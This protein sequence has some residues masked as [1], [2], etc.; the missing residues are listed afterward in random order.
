[1]TIRGLPLL[2]FGFDT[3]S[4]TPLDSGIS[5]SGSPSYDDETTVK[6]WYHYIPVCVV[7]LLILAPHPSLLFMLVDFHL[8][9][10]DQYLVFGIHLFVTYALTF[11]AFS[12]LIVC[13]ARDPGPIVIPQPV[14]S[15]DADDSLN[16]TEALMTSSEDY[17]QH[18]GWC[19]KCW[20]PRPER[21]HHCQMCGRCV[22]KMD[23]HCPWLANKCI[24]HRTYPA[25]IHFLTCI[26]LLAL[27]I[28][29]VSIFALKYAFTNPLGVNEVTPMHELGLA[30]AGIVI[31]LVI[32]PFLLY[33]FYLIST[34]QTTLEN[35][36][37]F[38][39]LRD[40]PPLPHGNHF[41][42][43]PPLEAEL[44]SAQRRLVKDAHG[45]IRLYD[46]GWRKNWFQNFGWVHKKTL[47]FR[48]F[49]G[50]SS[51]GD[52]KHFPRNPKSDELLARLAKELVNSEDPHS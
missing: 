20:S 47:L 13:I 27:Y 52:G 16:F 15:S 46:L 2:N 11:L 48:L 30:F 26:T 22:L 4:R 24:G 6:R 42:S 51:M 37:P 41:L 21:A 33:H 8:L 40:L 31:S 43:D 36:T 39:I 7:V 44:S 17:D 19:R 25:F 5:D 49:F 14:G 38:M 23:H 3:Q 18:S 28:A 32:G 1:M 50:G 45:Y 35:V 12:S 29:V 9:T 10:M 34:N